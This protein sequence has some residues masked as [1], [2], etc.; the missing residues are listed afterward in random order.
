MAKNFIKKNKT[1]DI[2]EYQK[3][4]RQE[5]KEYF[6]KKAKEYNKKNKEKVEIYQQQYR[7]K[8]KKKQEIIEKI[9]DILQKDIEMSYNIISLS[10]AIINIKQLSMNNYGVY[11]CIYNH[12]DELDDIV[13]INID[14]YS[15]VRVLD[16]NLMKEIKN[17]N[18]FLKKKY[19]KF[20]IKNF[21]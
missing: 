6:N 8:E 14:N 9:V 5:H 3:K 15:I 11:Y 19:A 7:K 10:M 12:D 2:K 20:L 18:S 16:L 13:I 21:S 17:D 4:Y 1:A